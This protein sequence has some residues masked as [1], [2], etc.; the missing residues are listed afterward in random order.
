MRPTYQTRKIRLVGTLQ[1]ETAENMIRNAPL[2]SERPLELILREE[3]KGRRLDQNAAMWAGPLRDIAEQ[4]WVDGRQFVAEVWHEHFKR[5]YLP[6]NDDLE[7]ALL[8][9]NPETYRKWDVTP[10]GD[11]VLVGSTTQLTER[12]FFIYMQQ[13]EADGAGLGVEFHVV[14]VRTAA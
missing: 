9:K 1:L 14:P 2:D 7:L 4:A 8:V 11:Q 5:K 6:E 3:S 12:G 10:R 13:I